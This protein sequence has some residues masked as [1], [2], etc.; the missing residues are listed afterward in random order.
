MVDLDAH[1][2]NGLKDL[3]G[4]DPL[5]FIFDMYSVYN[6]LHDYKMYKYINFN[7]PLIDYIA[8]E[9]YLG[10]FKNGLP[11]AL[12]EVTPD[13]IIYNA[14]TDI[15]ER[16]PLGKMAVSKEGIIERDTFVFAQAVTHSIPILMVLS[17]GYTQK[18]AEIVSESVE[19]LIRTFK[20]V[21][22]ENTLPVESPVKKK[23]LK[24]F[25]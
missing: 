14:G 21:D 19:N 25:K 23:P 12:A 24:F 8:D 7:Y 10:L 22:I 1:H 3:L 20:L 18:S 6:Y 11:R 17:G 16:D 15:Y 9:A 2:G 13:I 5:T 4:T